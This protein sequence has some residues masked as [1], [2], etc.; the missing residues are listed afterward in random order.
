VTPREIRA[1]R[2]SRR[3]MP[4]L[5]SF[6]YPIHGRGFER[7]RRIAVRLWGFAFRVRVAL[8]DV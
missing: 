6:A 2:L 8:L 5:W 3:F 1:V 4:K 7:S